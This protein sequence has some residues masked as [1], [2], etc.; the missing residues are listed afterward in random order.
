LRKWK[1]K[2]EIQHSLYFYKAGGRRF[3]FCKFASGFQEMPIRPLVQRFILFLK[4]RPPPPLLFALGRTFMGVESIQQN[5]I[6]RLLLM[7]HTRPWIGVQLAALV[8]SVEIRLK[9][10][11][12]AIWAQQSLAIQRQLALLTSRAGILQIIP[13][14]RFL[15]IRRFGRK[16]SI[17]SIDTVSTG[18]ASQK[19]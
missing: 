9:P 15:R 2:Q 12:L 6:G 7:L 10:I 8:I 4:L 3:Y 5:R 18:N 1:C 14:K 13:S 11:V 19:E 16:C 17:V